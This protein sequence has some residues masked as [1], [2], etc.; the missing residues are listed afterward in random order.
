MSWS[1]FLFVLDILSPKKARKSNP[2]SYDALREGI[3][4]SRLC[5]LMYV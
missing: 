4:L 5:V 3:V 1:S 2:T